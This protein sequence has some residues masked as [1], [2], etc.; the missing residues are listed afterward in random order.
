MFLIKDKVFSKN[1]IFYPKTEWI[2]HYVL[3]AHVIGYFG[4]VLVHGVVPKTAEGDF[5]KPFQGMF[6]FQKSDLSDLYKI[7]NDPILLSEMGLFAEG[8]GEIVQAYSWA[9][10]AF[11]LARKNGKDDILLMVSTMCLEYSLVNGKYDEAFESH[12][13]FAA[14]S[15]HLKGQP[16]EKYDNFKNSSIAEVLKEKPSED[17]NHAEDTA[18]DTAIIPMFM[19]VLLL[20]L[21]NSDTAKQQ[22]EKYLKLIFNYI[23]EASDKELWNQLYYICDGVLNRKITK[24]SIIDFG[25]SHSKTRR[26]LHAISL[27]GLIFYK[28]KDVTAMNDLLN[29]YPHFANTY[30]RFSAI[31]KYICI[32]FLKVVSENI[33]TNNFVGSKDEIKEKLIELKGLDP[34]ADN[35]YQLCLQTVVNT[36]EEDTKMEDNRRR[37]LYNFEKI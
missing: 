15:T 19:H 1:D 37:W 29:I 34:S 16:P 6:L 27:F 13:L 30:E 8:V 23:Q 33:L 35:C 20:N 2:K 17:W 5:T 36:F 3:S 11:D 24:Q 31:R 14:L 28:H 26:T 21:T 9:V 32:P 18:V 7:T 4:N 25:N 12:L 22:Q 10:R